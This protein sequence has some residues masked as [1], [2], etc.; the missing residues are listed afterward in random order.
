MSTD[1]KKQSGKSHHREGRKIFRKEILTSPLGVGAI[2]ASSKKL[3]KCMAQ[4]INLDQP[5][6]IIELGPG[7]G[8]VTQAI[9]DRGIDPERLIL[10]EQS[11][12]FVKHLK[13][14][15][16]NVRVIHGDATH[17]SQLLSSEHKPINAIL[18]SLPF[19]AIPDNIVAQM[20]RQVKKVMS[21]ESLFVQYTY[22]SMHPHPLKPF[23]QLKRVLSKI[24]W[25]NFPPAKVSVYKIHSEKKNE[26][27]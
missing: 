22:L 12:N 13:K 23:P 11:K 1:K 26:P 8:A 4:Q 6:F 19:R 20:V 10:V 24:V 16:P 25:L 9:L 7:T 2:C 21:N 5:G 18:S 15:F 14:R 3:S 27:R 17:L